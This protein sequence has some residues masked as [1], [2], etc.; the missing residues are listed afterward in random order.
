VRGFSGDEQGWA[1][2]IPDFVEVA[3]FLT[4]TPPELNNAQAA[5]R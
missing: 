2:R 4:A 3:L 5:L 1:A